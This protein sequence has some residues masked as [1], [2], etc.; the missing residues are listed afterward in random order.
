MT[1]LPRLPLDGEPD[2]HEIEFRHTGMGTVSAVVFNDEGLKVDEVRGH[3]FREAY[4]KVRATYP[5]AMW[6][7]LD[8]EEDA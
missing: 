5:Q 6:D 2:G 1:P 4:D 3:S 7:G 8:D